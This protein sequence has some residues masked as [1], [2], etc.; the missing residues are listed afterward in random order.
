MVNKRNFMVCRVLFYLKHIFNQDD[1]FQ[2]E[3][4]ARVLLEEKKNLTFQNNIK[5]VGFVTHPNHENPYA[6]FFSL[7]F[8]G[9][10]LSKIEENMKISKY[11]K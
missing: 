4:I 8:P 1:I 11:C 5:R 10:E 6:N 2:K 9:D 3:T 7:I